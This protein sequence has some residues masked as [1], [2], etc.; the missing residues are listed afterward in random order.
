MGGRMNRIAKFSLISEKRWIED[1]ISTFEL[2]EM[3]TREKAKEEYTSL[4][5][6]LRATEGSAGY[7]FYTPFDIELK[8]GESVKIPTGIRCKMEPGYVL[9]I[10][11]RSSLGFKYGLMLV[12]TI[13]VIDSDYY[14]SD[15]E[16]HIFIKMINT[17]NEG[18]IVKLK[19]GDAVAQGLFT[20]YG[21]TVDDEVTDKR[22]GG[23]GST[24]EKQS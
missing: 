19:K 13:G 6:P 23:V 15:N 22:N 16:G 10:V 3:G 7:D 8:P 2:T 12:N 24:N 14:G 9:L 11:P 21:I 4:K 17:N 1:W 20:A 18:K 5:L